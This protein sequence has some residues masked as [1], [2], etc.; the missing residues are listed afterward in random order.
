MIDAGRA[1]TMEASMSH[2]KSAAFMP[3]LLAG[4]VLILAAAAPAQ[5]QAVADIIDG[6]G[7]TKGK[8]TLIEDKDGIHVDVRAVGLPAGV[9][10]VHIHSVGTC[11]GP[12]FTSAGGTGTRR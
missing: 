10:A 5:R 11:T 1:R 2:F 12:D 6:Q 8:A 3:L 4:G 9:H 7:Q